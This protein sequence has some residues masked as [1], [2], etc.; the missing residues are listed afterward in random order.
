MNTQ[1]R[2]LTLLLLGDSYMHPHD[3]QAEKMLMAGYVHAVKTSN[4]IVAAAAG[5][6]LKG[7]S[8]RLC[9]KANMRSKFGQIDRSGR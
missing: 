3:E 8:R 2:S 1:M 4:Q 6:C 5:S 9:S 7:L